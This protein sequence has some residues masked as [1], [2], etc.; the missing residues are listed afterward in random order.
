MIVRM[1]EENQAMVVLLEHRYFGQSFPVENLSDENMKYLTI[2]QTLADLNHFA[3]QGMGSSLDVKPDM[4][5]WILLGNSYAGESLDTAIYWILKD[6][7]AIAG[8]LVSWAL[9]K[10]FFRYLQ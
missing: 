2:E 8:G 10:Y 6:I 4:H 9:L 7:L 5:P 3:T 1:A